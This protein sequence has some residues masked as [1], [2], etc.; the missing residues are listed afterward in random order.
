M[1]KVH[2]ELKT[3]MTKTIE[4]FIDELHTVRAGR[5]NPSLLDHITVEYYGTPTPLNQLASV[6]AP[7]AR[8]LQ[9]QPYDKGAMSDIEKAIL[10]SD[11]GLNPSNDGKVIRLS[12]PMLTEERRKE[13]VKVVKKMAEESKVAIRNERRHAIDQLKKMEKNNE[14][15]EDDLK[16]AEKEVQELVD[17]HIDRVD[18]LAEKKEKEIMAV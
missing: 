8:L 17:E 2:S 1:N 4:V 18:E 11:L 6:S 5:A 10:T 9:I 16:R 13:L 14:L 15:T 3:K 12:I 7:E